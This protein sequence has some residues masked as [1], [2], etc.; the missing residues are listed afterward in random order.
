MIEKRLKGTNSSYNHSHQKTYKSEAK[1][2]T[3]SSVPDTIFSNKQ[4]ATSNKQQATSNK[5]QATSNK[6]QA[7]KRHKFP[8]RPNKFTAKYKFS[9]SKPHAQEQIPVL[10]RFLHYTFNK[11]A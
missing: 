11:T 7:T 1:H 6:Q 10:V 9:H 4:Q 3:R 8:L 5:Q 2:L